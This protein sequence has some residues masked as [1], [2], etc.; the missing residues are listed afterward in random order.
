MLKYGSCAVYVMAIHTKQSM[1]SVLSCLHPCAACSRTR[2]KKMRSMCVKHS[3][4]M[5]CIS[6]WVP[7]LKSCFHINQKYSSSAGQDTG[8]G[9]QSTLN[10]YSCRSRCSLWAVVYPRIVWSTEQSALAS[11]LI[12]YNY[13]ITNWN[14]GIRF[15]D[16]HI[17]L[18]L[19]V[20]DFYN[21]L[22]FCLLQVMVTSYEAAI[23]I[24]I[25]FDMDNR[26]FGLPRELVVAS[27][28]EIQSGQQGTIILAQKMRR[29]CKGHIIKT[30][31][32]AGRRSFVRQITETG[33]FVAVVVICWNDVCFLLQLQL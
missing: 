21:Q 19:N 32:K 23:P 27:A 13:E 28:G 2:N 14:Q 3:C 7:G 26:I 30:Y 10:S 24:I 20:Y 1:D 6:C 16:K 8:T 25:E 29:N 11:T 31:W 4:C 22:S 18:Y 17:P 33:L 9:I 15:E 12:H 5:S